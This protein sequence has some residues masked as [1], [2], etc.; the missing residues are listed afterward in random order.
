MNAKA[1]K[2]ATEP[3]FKM[4]PVKSSSSITAHGYDAATKTLAVTFKG[5]GQT[6]HY[7]GVPADKA[8]AFGKAK[9]AGAFFASDIRN[10]FKG[11]A[12]PKK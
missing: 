5:N 10:A 7:A 6:Y 9:S 1:K 4:T 3:V 2:P 8:E 11:V 12:A